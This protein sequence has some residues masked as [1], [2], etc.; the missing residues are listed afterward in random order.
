ME[1]KHWLILYDVPSR[2]GKSRAFPRE[3]TF[4]RG[5]AKEIGGQGGRP[6]PRGV[7]QGRTIWNDSARIPQQWP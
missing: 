1:K 4:G 3:R 5:H 2:C 7:G 6:E